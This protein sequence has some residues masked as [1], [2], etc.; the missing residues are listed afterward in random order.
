M[1][2]N[3]GSYMKFLSQGSN[4]GI[5]GDKNNNAHVKISCK[6][7]EFFL[8]NSVSLRALHFLFTLANNKTREMDRFNQPLPDAFVPFEIVIESRPNANASHTRLS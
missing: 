6:E 5:T 4:V 2:Q 3:H 8:E 7:T 1:L